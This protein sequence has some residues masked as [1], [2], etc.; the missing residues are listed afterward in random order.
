MA[1]IVEELARSPTLR[2]CSSSKYGQTVDKMLFYRVVEKGLDTHV[3]YIYMYIEKEV[4]EHNNK[5][6]KMNELST[7]V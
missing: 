1:L 4:S 6:T 7:N 2:R 3:I 5:K